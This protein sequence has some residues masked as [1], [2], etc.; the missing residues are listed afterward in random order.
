M[1][2]FPYGG[3]YVVDH[4]AQFPELAAV[5]DVAPECCHQQG[6]V[7]AKDGGLREGLDP[8]HVKDAGHQV[9]DNHDQRQHG[10]CA[11]GIEDVLALVPLDERFVRLLDLC[12]QLLQV[13]PAED[14]PTHLACAGEES[15]AALTDGL[16]FVFQLLRREVG[17]VCSTQLQCEGVCERK[18]DDNS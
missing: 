6:N 4:L 12:L 8:H 15:D 9:G 7:E 1:Y 14:L 3:C 18:R 5:S 13:F 10:W 2:L 11:V 16:V 17:L